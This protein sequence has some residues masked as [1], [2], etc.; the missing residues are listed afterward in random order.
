MKSP[1]AERLAKEVAQLSRGEEAPAHSMVRERLD[2]RE[3]PTSFAAVRAEIDQSLA[4]SLVA[5]FTD[6]M[7]MVSES[8][9]G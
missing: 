1:T 8:E 9:A 3:N 6:D 7:E 4:D 2:E 5:L